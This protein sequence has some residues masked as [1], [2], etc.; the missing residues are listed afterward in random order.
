MFKKV[1]VADVMAAWVN[2]AYA[3]PSRISGVGLAFA[4]LA[5]SVQIYCDFSGY[6]DIAICSAKLFGIV[7]PE[8][9]RQP[10]LS[11]TLREFWQRWHMTLS[12]WLRDYLYVPLGGNRHGAGRTYLNLMITMVLGG[13]WHGS[14]WNWVVWGAIQGVVMSIERMTGFDRT[15]SSALARLVRWAIT[16]FIVLVSWV[17]FRARS[18]GDA[19]LVLTRIGSFAPGE[20]QTDLRAAV[21]ASI[22]L[23]MVLLAGYFDFRKRWMDYVETRPRQLRWLT[24]ACVIILSLTFSGASKQEFIYF[25]F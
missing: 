22:G 25:A 17:F 12:R 13:L 15:P 1:Y 8:N 19:W 21:Y 4:T 18:L 7:M 9:F 5:F 10:Y 20:F 6:S 23:L 2:D 14:G 11:T 3:D 16:L 24:Y